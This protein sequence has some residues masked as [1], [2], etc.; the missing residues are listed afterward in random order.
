[1][2]RWVRFFL[3][4]IIGFGIGLL[5]GWLIDPVEYVDTFPETLREDYK[6]DYI[7]MV[8]EAYQFERDIDLAVERLS[9]LGFVPPESLVQEAMYFAIQSGYSPV[10]LGILRNLSDGLSKEA[11]QVDDVPVEDSQP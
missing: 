1:M 10:D 9:F 4:L 7:L 11:F 6:A 2:S 3:V 5:Y 8:A